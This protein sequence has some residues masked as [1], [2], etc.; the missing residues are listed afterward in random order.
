MRNDS[1][2]H[3]TEMLSQAPLKH[4]HKLQQKNA[5]MCYSSTYAQTTEI[6]SH[7][8]ERLSHTSLKHAFFF[9]EKHLF[10]QITKTP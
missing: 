8:N 7:T 1:L 5:V 6:L 10:I 2:I 9:A 3:F 4:A